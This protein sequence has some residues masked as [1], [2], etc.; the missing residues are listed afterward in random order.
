MTT[1][2]VPVQTAVHIPTWTRGT[3]LKVWAAAAVPMAMLAWGVAPLLAHA[4]SGPSAL[5]RAVILC[6][7]AGLA[8]QFIL[9]LTIVRREQGTLN[10]PVVEDALWLR[11]PAQPRTGQRGGR[12][13][14]ILVPCLLLFG[15]EELVPSIPPAAGHDLPSFLESAAGSS[16]LSGNWGWFAIIAAMTI[17]NTV[18]G[19]ELLFRGL[20]LPRMRGAFGRW[21][22]V[23]NGVLFAVYHLHMPW[24]IPATLVDTVAIAYPCR[25][26]RSAV[27]GI[28]VHSAQTVVVLAATLSVVLK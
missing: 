21:D 14:L 8:W 16:L 5:P 2:D 13:W 22:W 7:T 23:A 20:L 4:F 27:I 10:W 12:I 3:V 15:A 6:L 26:Y 1:Y 11:A 18:L 19:E 17:F 25:R 28:I 9:I 24:A